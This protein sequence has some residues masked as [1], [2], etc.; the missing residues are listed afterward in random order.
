[1][2]SSPE[3]PHESAIENKPNVDNKEN[4]I[5]AETRALFRSAIE[6]LRSLVVDASPTQKDRKYTR[7]IMY[8]RISLFNDGNSGT[9]VVN[10]CWRVP[11]HRSDHIA[12]ALELSAQLYENPD[13]RITRDLFDALN[14]ET[15]AVWLVINQDATSTSPL[16]SSSP[17]L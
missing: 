11:E 16:H 12:A 9:E 7:T 8:Y 1:M 5:N 15:L 13:M 2:P 17:Q 6:F 4:V 3:T 14:K 10:K